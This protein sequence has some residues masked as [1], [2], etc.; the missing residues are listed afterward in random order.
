M[1]EGLF[2]YFWV[3]GFLG[4]SGIELNGMEILSVQMLN[5]ESAPGFENNKSVFH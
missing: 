1:P 3:C 5:K 2:D 4:G